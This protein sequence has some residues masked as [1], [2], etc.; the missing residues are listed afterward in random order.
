MPV[1]W[2]FIVRF[3]VCCIN[4]WYCSFAT[5]SYIRPCF[6]ASVLILG[7]R[8][9]FGGLKIYLSLFQNVLG[10]Y[11]IWQLIELIPFFLS[12]TQVS[13]QAC[14]TVSFSSSR[15]FSNVSGKI[16]LKKEISELSYCFSV[17][18]RGLSIAIILNANQ[19]KWWPFSLCIEGLQ[20]VMFGNIFKLPSNGLK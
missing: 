3:N 12:L 14:L 6:R 4:F 20:R 17:W 11:T 1:C 13:L 5:A 16:L 8:Y 15:E 9:L 7:F 19:M 2:M 10:I 18:L